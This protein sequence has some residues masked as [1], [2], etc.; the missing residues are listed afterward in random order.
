MTKRP[1]SPF[2]GQSGQ[3]PNSYRLPEN[4]M[5]GLSSLGVVGV[6][7]ASALRRC[8]PR[9]NPDEANELALSLKRLLTEEMLSSKAKAGLLRV[10]R[11]G[12]DPSMSHLSAVSLGQTE[13][14]QPFMT[15]ENLTNFADHNTTSSG[16]TS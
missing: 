3:E 2:N 4:G 9:L 8:D 13:R 6:R 12:L 11:R 16:S 1:Y 5:D 14:L 7:L 15:R 10:L